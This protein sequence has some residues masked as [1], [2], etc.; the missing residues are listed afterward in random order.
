MPLLA[1]AALG[2]EPY[3]VPNCD[4]VFGLVCFLYGITGVIGG[5]N[6]MRRGEPEEGMSRIKSGALIAAVP[7]IMRIVFEVFRCNMCG[8]PQ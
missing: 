6:Q 4:T 5:G 8:L 3:I 1:Q 2:K 7:L